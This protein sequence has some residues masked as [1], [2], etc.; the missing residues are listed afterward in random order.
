MAEIIINDFSKLKELV[1][2]NLKEGT[3][4]SIEMV[5]EGHGRQ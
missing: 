3:I 2:E 4:I 5:R 1:T